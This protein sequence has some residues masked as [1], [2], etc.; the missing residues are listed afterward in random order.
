MPSYARR[1]DTLQS[2]RDDIARA[3]GVQVHDTSQM[4]AYAPGWPDSIWVYAGQVVFVEHKNSDERLTE[5]ER[6]WHREFLGISA[7]VRS[8]E[9]ALRLARELR[10]IPD[11]GRDERE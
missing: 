5:A 8:D 2:R 9:D 1:R 10:G 11:G 7:V 3:L 6:K 4:A